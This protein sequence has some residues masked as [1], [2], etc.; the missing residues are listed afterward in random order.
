MKTNRRTEGWVVL[1]IKFW[2]SATT[3]ELYEQAKA[4]I[5]RQV[6]MDITSSQGYIIQSERAKKEAK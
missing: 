6:W 1:P 2:V 4:N 3:P 5:E